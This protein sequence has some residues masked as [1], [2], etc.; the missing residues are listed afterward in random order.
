M[1]I[2][3]A[4]ISTTTQS[5]DLQVDALMKAGCE[6]VFQ[7][8]ASGRKADRP[9]LQKLLTYARKGD[10][11]I[12]WKLDRLGRSLIDLIK[13]VK[14]LQEKEV[15]LVSIRDMIDT[16]TPVGK[17]TFHLMAALAEF[18][19]D[20]ISERT[21]AGLASAKARG[22]NGG[23]PKGMSERLKKI[24]VPVKAM[25]DSDMT[26]KEITEY[27]GISNGSIYRI[28]DYIKLKEIDKSKLN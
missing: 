6:K 15:E 24:A 5:Y 7:E 9:E 27:F 3:Y 20:L 12:V 11:I 21:K 10:V 13:V 19:S 26:N 18:E 16:T 4:R 2:G 1:R 14:L 25:Y 23:R 8:S 17:F 22:R 28:L